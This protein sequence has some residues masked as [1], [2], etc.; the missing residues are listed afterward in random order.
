MGPIPTFQV[1]QEALVSGHPP[2]AMTLLIRLFFTHESD[3][4]LVQSCQGW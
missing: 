2:G 4:Q 3:D 1:E